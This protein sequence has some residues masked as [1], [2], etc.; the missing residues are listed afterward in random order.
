MRTGVRALVTVAAVSVWLFPGAASAARKVY[1][2]VTGL[3]N[4][5]P[6]QGARVEAWDRDYGTDDKMGETLTLADGSYVINYEGKHWDSCPE[7]MTCF[8]PDIYIRVKVNGSRVF[9]SSTHSNQVQQ[10]DLRIDASVPMPA[11]VYGT[12]TLDG[13]PYYGKAVKVLDRDY[14]SWDELM[15]QTTTAGDGTYQ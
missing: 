9:T 1:G 6:V 8:R 7:T 10:N 13:L 15:G 5:A 12:V 4:G 11:R 14:F 3:A 2:V